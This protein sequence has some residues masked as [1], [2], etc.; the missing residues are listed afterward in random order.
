MTRRRTLKPD[1]K[2]GVV[3]EEL[4]GVESAAEICREHWLKP[5]VL[6]R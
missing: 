5:Q 6:A 2:A 3:L 1:L 4:T